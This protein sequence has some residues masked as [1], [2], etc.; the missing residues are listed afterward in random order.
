MHVHANN[1]EIKIPKYE[2]LIKNNIVNNI[3]TC[4]K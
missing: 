1:S 2:F 4:T 3:Q